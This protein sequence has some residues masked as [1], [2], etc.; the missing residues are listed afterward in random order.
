MS[1]SESDIAGIVCRAFMN[2][3]ERAQATHELAN[4]GANAIP[5]LRAILSGEAKNEFGVPFRCLGM[6]VDCA[7]VVIQLLGAEGHPLE[8]FVRMELN[9]GHPYA[10]GALRAINRT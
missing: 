10:E 9:A 3:G 6:P 5:I 1:H 4:H 7:L 2:P 8:D